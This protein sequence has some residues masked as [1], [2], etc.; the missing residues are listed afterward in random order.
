MCLSPEEE[1]DILILI[2]I[3]F[4]IHILIFTM[5]FC[6]HYRVVQSNHLYNRQGQH[7]FVKKS[8][9]EFLPAILFSSP[10]HSGQTDGKSQVPRN[11]CCQWQALACD[12]Q[13]CSL[14]ICR[15][16][17]LVELANTV[18]DVRSQ[19]PNNSSDSETRCLV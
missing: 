8:R 18:P 10:L 11:S 1:G 15:Y 9:H 13:H 17:A 4:F 6:K 3:I 5:F 12:R 2:T 16:I 14:K 19:N 7:Y